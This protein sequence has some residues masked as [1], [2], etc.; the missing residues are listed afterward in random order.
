MVIKKSQLKSLIKTVVREAIAERGGLLNE[1]IP[2]VQKPGIPQGSLAKLNPQIAAPSKPQKMGVPSG[3][4][5]PPIKRVK[6]AG[7]TSEDGASY[8]EHEEVLLIKVMK[9]I[10]DKLSAM[11]GE[12]E[13]VPKEQPTDE[14]EFQGADD[15]AP[16]DMADEEPSEEPAPFGGD[17]TEGGDDVTEPDFGN[18]EEEPE[19]E[20]ETEEE[21]EE[22]K[23]EIDEAAY[24][25]VAHRAATD[26]KENKALRIQ[27][28]PKVNEASFKK[29]AKKAYTD[30][31]EDKARRIQTEPD[32][33]EAKV[34]KRS[35]VTAKDNP[36][37]PKN[38]RDPE[39]PMSEAKK[40]K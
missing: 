4:L 8:D 30:A 28:E 16:T 25:V 11:H 35:Y 13:L 31:K 18:T 6:E 1:N 2:P 37:D 20:P 24:K 17:D 39:V 5:P 10:A 26:A 15:A 27:T 29:M 38:V 36:A 12:T 3:K 22:E 14:P 34:Q 7:L 9:L 21:P 33:N 32:V 40:R 23:P 19:A